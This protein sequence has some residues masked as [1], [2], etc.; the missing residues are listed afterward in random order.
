MFVR[1]KKTA[2]YQYLQLVHNYRDNGKPKQKVIA[3]LGRLEELVN[4]GSIESIIESLE[5]Y[6]KEVM[7]V[8]TNKSDI[9]ANSTIIGPPLVFERLWKEVGIPEIIRDLLI[10]RKF[11][12][13]VERAVF[14]TV[15]NR[16]M[17]PGSDR[18]CNSWHKQYQ[19]EN[20]DGLNLHHFYRAMDFLGSN[21]ELQPVKKGLSPR[22]IKDI[23]EE[24][25]F[26][27][28]RTLFTQMSMVFFDTT[29]LY[30][31]G[32]GGQTIGQRGHS[33]DN[34]PDLKQMI[35]GAV[36][37]EQG[38]PVCCELW[39]GNT[40]DV[41]TLIPVVDRIRKRFKITDFC[42]VADRGMISSKTIEEL[43][44][45]GMYYILG[46]RMRKTDEIKH[47]VLNR[48]GR[49]KEIY[50]DLDDSK[51]PSPLKVK[52]VFV[53]GSRHVVCVN[54]KQARKDKADRDAIIESLKESLKQ[55]TK[56][57]VG[58]K[59]YRKYVSI[60]K[61]SVSIDV[62]K[63]KEEERYD[64]KWV[65]K[66]NLDISA[67]QV[68]LNYKE[69]WMV[70]QVFRTTKSIFETRPIYHQND[71]TIKGHVFCSFLALVLQKMLFNK[72]DNKNMDYEWEKIKLDLNDLKLLTIDKGDN[73]IKIRTECK[74]LCAGV[75]LACGIAVPT[76]L[77]K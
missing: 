58:N 73:Q 57:L 61:N 5:R 40:A 36:L 18:Y 71:E 1:L 33:K 46:A 45:Q 44:Q 56:Q 13:D 66:T 27:K 28:R 64:G 2:G 49:Y 53:D 10:G 41:K 74:G 76:T 34:R 39:P 35:V 26:D 38:F 59:G 67:S 19:I 30:F 12:F 14:L 47:Q 25:M 63:I 72:L 69:L 70:E 29:S 32:E 6:S 8:I 37:D 43:E 23:I 77:Q 24:R 54:E 31:E 48:A 68:A 3:T 65:L 11:E 4:N 75:F 42:I 60:K 62:D 16:L 21:F 55:G 22:C 51:A 9:K 17:N 15:F 7:M 52:E 50:P 20:T